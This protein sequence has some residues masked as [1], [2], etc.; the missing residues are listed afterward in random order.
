[1]QTILF[2]VALVLV[3]LVSTYSTWTISQSFAQAQANWQAER[4]DLLDRLMARNLP[5]VKQSQALERRAEG[6]KPTSKRQ[7]DAKLIESARMAE[8]AGE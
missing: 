6:A 3:A 5:E 4:K 1:M 2:I 7:N 8:R